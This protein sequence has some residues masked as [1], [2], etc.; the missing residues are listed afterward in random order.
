MIIYPLKTKEHCGTRLDEQDEASR[1]IGMFTVYVLKST[2]GH[3]SYVG[4]TADISRRIEEHNLGKSNYTKKYMPWVIVHT[5]EFQELSQARKREKYL[6]SKA[7][8]KFLKIVF[9]KPI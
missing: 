3:K 4:L 8:R 1:L 9:S 6:K 5:E 7:G 2:I